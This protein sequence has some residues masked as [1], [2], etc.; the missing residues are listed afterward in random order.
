MVRLSGRPCSSWSCQVRRRDPTN[1]CATI[2]TA[3]DSSIDSQSGAAWTAVERLALAARVV[4]ELLARG[5]LGAQ[6]APRH[7]RVRVALDLDDA[8]VLDED[9]LAAADGAVRAHALG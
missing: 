5:S 2:S 4:D 9:A 6:T 1:R 8:A 7:R 3:V